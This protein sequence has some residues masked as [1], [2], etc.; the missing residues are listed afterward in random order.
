MLSQKELEAARQRYGLQPVSQDSSSGLSPRMQRLTQVAQQAQQEQDPRTQLSQT[1]QD[2]S[3]GF[4]KSMVQG[5]ARPFVKLGTTAAAA[6]DTGATVGKA[7]YHKATGNEA[8]YQADRIVT[9]K[10]YTH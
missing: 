2:E 6:V 8:A 7:I 4:F 10:Q 5:I 3:P 9:G 1:Q